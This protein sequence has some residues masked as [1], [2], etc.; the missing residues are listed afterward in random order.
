MLVITGATGFIGRQI[1]PKLENYFKL[2]IVSRDPNRATDLFPSSTICSYDQLENLDLAGSTFVHL[3]AQNNDQ[4]A[5]PEE[6]KKANVEFLLMVATVAKNG[7]A[8]H[9]INLCSTHALEPKSNDLYG[10]SKQ[11]GASRLH[12]FWPE[13]AINLY[14]PSVYGTSFNGRMGFVNN[15]PVT[16][17][18]P[19][20]ALMR[21]IKPIVSVDCLC[22]ALVDLSEFRAD[23]YANEFSHEV[24]LADPDSANRLYGS[25]KRVTDLTVSLAMIILGSWAM[26]LIALYIRLD[27]SGPAVVAQKRVGRH[28]KIFTC[29]KFRTMATGTADVGT[30]DVAASSVTSAGI[31]LRKTKLD[32]LPQLLNVVR[33]EMSLVGPR[34][35]LPIQQEVIKHRV[36]RNVLALKP[37][38]TGLAQIKGADMSNP[39]RLAALDC[40]YYAF[41]TVIGDLSILVRTALGGGSGDRVGVTERGRY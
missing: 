24:F 28:G 11:C 13:G 12:A 14:I 25:I 30:H 40:R 38:I 8:T 35:C 39:A 5:T 6:F 9:L 33:N 26:L 36:A 29:Y 19:L 37:G 34:P 10:H 3:A 18:P 2:I 22:R 7:G 27:S 32:E 1:V 17:R 23:H 20:I 21:L 15:I 16:M 31:F 41:R 4:T